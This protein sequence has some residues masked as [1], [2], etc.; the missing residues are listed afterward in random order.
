MSPASAPPIPGRMSPCLR[1]PLPLPAAGLSGFVAWEHCY[2]DNVR[3]REAVERRC[4]CNVVGRMNE[5]GPNPGIDLRSREAFR[6]EMKRNKEHRLRRPVG[7]VMA[8]LPRLL[9]A[10]S[11]K[12]RSALARQ[13]GGDALGNAWLMAFAAIHA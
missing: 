8:N 10:N 13:R 2:I 7:E 12:P 11:P 4:R 3:D 1:L 6:L 9:F 5:E